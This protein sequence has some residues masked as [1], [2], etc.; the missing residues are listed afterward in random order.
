MAKNDHGTQMQQML[1]QYL[2]VNSYTVWRLHDQQSGYAGSCNP[3]D[4]IVVKTGTTYLIE[5][6][7][8]KNQSL[9]FSALTP[10][11]RQCQLSTLSERD[12]RNNVVGVVVLGFCNRGVKWI[13]A[14]QF[15]WWEKHVKKSMRWEDPDTD[16]YNIPCPA[17]KYFEFPKTI[18]TVVNPVTIIPNNP[19]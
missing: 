2:E 7:C 11:Q 10:Y 5:V 9:S 12:K 16:A 4:F 15:F 3:G 8:T 18:P 17:P 19:N 6:K 1:R 13:P 14:E